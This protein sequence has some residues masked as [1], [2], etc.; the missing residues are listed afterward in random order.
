MANMMA[1][2]SKKEWEKHS[3]KRPDSTYVNSI[4]FHLDRYDSSHKLLEPLAKRGSRLF[5]VTVR[6]DD[7][8]LLV[9]VLESPKHDG[10]GWRAKPNRVTVR[11]ITAHKAALG[12]TAAAG[13]LA[14]SLQTPRAL[15]DEQGE[16]L[17][18]AG[19]GTSAAKPAKR[20][21]AVKPTKPEKPAKAAKPAGKGGKLSDD[22]KILIE[23][24]GT[25]IEDE[26]LD[27]L[28]AKPDKLIAKGTFSDTVQSIYSGAFDSADETL[29]L[30][31]QLA[32]FANGAKM[33]GRLESELKKGED[34]T[35][36]ANELV[37]AF[38]VS[39]LDAFATAIAALATGRDTKVPAAVKPLAPHL[40]QQVTRIKQ[41]LAQ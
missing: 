41:A 36:L 24:A 12:L 23:A 19:A 40:A 4:C 32:P 13:K 1:L 38:A 35:S 7:R 18:A 5:L 25:Q 31:R 10:T 33:L 28:R 29:P 16:L 26:Y 39:A 6:A 15:T 21:K 8:L 2:V 20:A 37:D 17:I 22:L 9:A 3:W 11:D 27:Q 30:L 14:M 34:A